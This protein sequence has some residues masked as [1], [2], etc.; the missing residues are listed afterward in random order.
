MRKK[1]KGKKSNISGIGVL[2]KKSPKKSFR[3]H[4]RDQ[5]HKE[6]L[7]VSKFNYYH[8]ATN[9]KMLFTIDVQLSEKSQRACIGKL[10][11]PKGNSQKLWFT[12][13]KRNFFFYLKIFVH[14]SQRLNGH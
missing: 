13:N 8:W 4:Y 6:W 14:F 3:T 12:K 5:E 9:W 7:L 10:H 1:K 2:R 11:K